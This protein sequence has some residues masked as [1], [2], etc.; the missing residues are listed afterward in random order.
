MKKYYKI[1][2]NFRFSYLHIPVKKYIDKGEIYL[3]SVKKM[4]FKVDEVY[5]DKV[6]KGKLMKKY[7][8]EGKLEDKENYEDTMEEESVAVS[9]THLTLPTTPYV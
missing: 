5:M 1:L 8:S 6:K 2:V 4:D 3:I 7:L 9:Y